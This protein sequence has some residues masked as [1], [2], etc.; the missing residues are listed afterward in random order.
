[1]QLYKGY[2]KLRSQMIIANNNERELISE[3][4]WDSVRD[5]VTQ[6]NPA[7]AQQIDKLPLG[8][9]HTFI[10]VSYP[11]GT[12]ILDN[13]TLQLP[14]NKGRFISYTDAFFP[15]E[16]KEKL[17]YSSIPVSVLLNNSI[18]V[19][20]ETENR[21][22]PLSLLPQGIT[23]GLW[24]TLDP[25]S[26]LFV[27]KLW[28]ITSGTRTLFFLPRISDAVSHRRIQ[29]EFKIRSGAPKNIID[30][31]A[32]FCEIIA[33]PISKVTWHTDL[34]ILTKA[35]FDKK[36]RKN[37][38]WRHFD[39]FLLEVA[40][41]Q[42]SHWRSKMYFEIIWE[43]FSLAIV[44]RNL[45]P[46]QNQ[47]N[48]V[49]HLIG[50]GMGIFPGFRPSTDNQAAPID[51]IQKVYMDIYGL[52]EYAPII[53]QPWWFLSGQDQTKLYYSLNFP[54]QLDYISKDIRSTLEEL[55]AIM[56]LT[57][58]LMR[59]VNVEDRQIFRMMQSMHFEYYHSEDDVLNQIK[60]TDE[61]INDD[62][63]FVEVLNSFQQQKLPTHASFLR[64]C[65][66]ISNSQSPVNTNSFE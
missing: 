7:L 44:K 9:E 48:A 26:S 18:E 37:K 47:I 58:T 59:R 60:K 52:K 30:Q 63:S 22:I 21:V 54:T 15:N 25:R 5:E 42:S 49:K 61:I 1:M 32:V 23:F 14:D 24:E 8:K 13:G 55:R 50:I 43:V 17:Y 6:V 65:V 4:E 19:Y 36:Y 33:T 16:L 66:S 57:D 35:W 27:E 40:W 38:E 12:K 53:M 28:Q 2:T 39:Q 3:V 41:K 11:Y 34:L 10:K 31:W 45:H 64:G 20:V 62:P 51:Y 29:N 56:R 46:T